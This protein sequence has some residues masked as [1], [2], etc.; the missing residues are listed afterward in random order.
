MNIEIKQDGLKMDM[1]RQAFAL[2]L[3]T[4]R[5]RTGRTQ[6]EA[7]EILGCSRYTIIDVEHAKPVSWR[8]A[9]KLFA[10]LAEQLRKE[11]QR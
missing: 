10:R 1:D 2:E 3:Q 11:A 4:W 8:T 7:G 6:I 9:Y 5:I